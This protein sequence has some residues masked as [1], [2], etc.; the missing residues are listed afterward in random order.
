MTRFV[1]AS[2]RPAITARAAATSVGAGRPR[3][4]GRGEIALTT[5]SASL[6]SAATLRRSVASPRLRVTR[7]SGFE[8]AAGSRTTPM[9]W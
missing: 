1:P 8:T 7:G 5:A 3:A 9:I 2:R 4:F 6:A